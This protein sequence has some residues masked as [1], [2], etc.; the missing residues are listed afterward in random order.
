MR[1]LLRWGVGLLVV[2]AVL[3][4]ASVEA[5]RYFAPSRI[6]IATIAAR[7]GEFVVETHTRGTLRAVN[8]AMMVAP[9]VGGTLM[10]TTVMPPGASVKKGDVALT[11]DREDLQNSL[12]AAISRVD[13]AEQTIRKAKADAAIKEHSD[14]VDLMKAGFAVRAAELDV[15]KNETVSAIDGQ[16][17]ILVLEAAR[18]KL[19]Q[20]QEDISARKSSDAADLAL[21]EEKLTKAKFDQTQAETRLQQLDVK[22][23]MDGL[24]SLRTNRMAAGGM[25]YP[26][27]PDFG[28]G[29]QVNGGNPVVDVVDN[30]NLEMSAQINETDRGNLKEGQSVVIHLDALPDLPLEGKVKSLGSINGRDWDSSP[31]KTFE[32]VFVLESGPHSNDPRLRPGLSGE[33]VIITE[34]APNV[35]FLPQQAV[36]EKESKQWVYLAKGGSNFQRL[37]VT[38]GR[39]SES[40]VEITKGLSG[41][42]RVALADPEERSAAS[43]KKSNPLSS[44]PGGK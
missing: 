33:V 44:S 39:R 8:S 17:N 4:G 26:D 1:A 42:E 15:S 11:F 41:G 20:L 10:I 43:K 34:K 7:R 24:L 29:D 37:E 16:K 2:G 25:W 22:A 5:T 38:V 36:I 18:K 21:N 23:P 14:Q 28:I 40:Q 19:A 12:D 13:E 9:N 6:E 35:V 30:T 31:N 32:G 27:L 3:T